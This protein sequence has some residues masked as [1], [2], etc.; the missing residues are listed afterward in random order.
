MKPCLTSVGWGPGRFSLPTGNLP[1]A[2]TLMELLVVIAIIGLLSGLLLPALSRAK[3]AAQRIS[4][5]NNLRQLQLA[6]LGYANDHN[7]RLVLNE[8]SLTGSTQMDWHS[9]PPSWV[10]GNAFL[11]STPT[12]IQ[13]GLLFESTGRDKKTYLCPSDTSTVRNQKRLL[14]TR[15]YSMSTYMNGTG[16]ALEPFVPINRIWRNQSDITVPSPAMA[17]VFIDNHPATT[18]GGSFIVLQPGSQRANWAWAHFPDARHQGSANLSYADGH[19]ESH[20]WLE[21]NTLRLARECFWG[22]KYVPPGDR[23]VSF[24][25]Q[26][27]PIGPR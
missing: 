8:E 1:T 5:L 10:T 19:A 9:N 4:C 13:R 26:R 20:R 18:A 15:H 16:N 17:F 27:I 21:S 3:G 2:F 12:N 11:D 6:S 7:D 23:D 14:R 25:Q 22:W 24:L